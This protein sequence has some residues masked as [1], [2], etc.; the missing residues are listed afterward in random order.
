MR[1]SGTI[2][3]SENTRRNPV[4][5]VV[6]KILE[7]IASNVPMLPSQRVWLQRRRGV[8]IGKNVFIGSGVL[9]DQ[10]FPEKIS[11]G[12]NATILAK[13]IIIAHSI[14]PKHFKKILKNKTAA[15]EI[16]EGTYI[17]AGAII[18]PGVKIGKYSVVGAGGV[19]TKS[20]P[21]YSKAVGSPAKVIGKIDKKLVG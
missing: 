1:T 6:N 20:I 5:A 13:T 19:V 15:V 7:A 3:L 16:C 10:A 21:P 17:G 9:I 8:K 11:I 12:D 4:R 18:M 14:Y 2:E